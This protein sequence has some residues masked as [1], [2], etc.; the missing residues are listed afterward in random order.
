MRSAVVRFAVY[1]TVL[2]DT[3]IHFDYQV[4]NNDTLC[5]AHDCPIHDTGLDEYPERG[6][7]DIDPIAIV[8]KKPAP[9]AELL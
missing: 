8:V 2:S 9:R 3:C 4:A 5:G 7:G 1:G 6:L